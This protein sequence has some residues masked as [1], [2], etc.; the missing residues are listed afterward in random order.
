LVYD[1]GKIKGPCRR[2][3][4]SKVALDTLVAPPYNLDKMTRELRME[5]NQ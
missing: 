5:H 1:A 2:L 4:L 3:Q